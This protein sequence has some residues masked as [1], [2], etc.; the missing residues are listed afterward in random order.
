MLSRIDHHDLKTVTDVRIV[1]ERLRYE[2]ALS[3]QALTSSVAGLGVSLGRAL[4]STAY[5]MGLKV[6]YALVIRM[7]QRRRK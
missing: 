6:A 7:L 2:V 5:R 3:E 1:K 4:K